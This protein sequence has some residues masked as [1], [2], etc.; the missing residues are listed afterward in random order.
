MQ[1]FFYQCTFRSFTWVLIDLHIGRA[2][3]LLDTE[4]TV[5]QASVQ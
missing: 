4:H 1:P 5:A 3:K 2:Y